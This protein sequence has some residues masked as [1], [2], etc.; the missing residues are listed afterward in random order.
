MKRLLR[1][2]KKNNRLIV[3]LM[4]GTSVDGVDA[5]LVQIKGS[6]LKTNI[7]QI[8]Y[9]T[10]PYPRDLEEL[11]LINSDSESARLREI[12][13]LN[14]LLGEFFADAA[15]KIIKKAR[16]KK[17]NVDLIGTHGQTIYHL[18]EKEKMFRKMIRGTM[19]IG[20]GEV[21][22]KKTGIVTVE[23]FR[24]GDVAVGGSGA[25]LVPYFDYVM[26]SSNKKD[27]A[28]LNIGGIA[29]ITVIP[30]K[31]DITS[32]FAFDTGPGN[33][34]IDYL[35]KKYFGKDY[36]KNGKIAS[37]GKVNV[38]LLKFL[39]EHEYLK[40]KPPKS[41]GREIFG[42]ILVEKILTIFKDVEPFD[43]VTTFSEYTALS[44]YDAYLRFV[45]P[46]YEIEEVFVSGGGVHNRYIMNAL[47][48]YFGR[49]RVDE[50]TEIGYSSDAKEAICFAFL[51][52][53]TISGN[54]GNIPSATGARKRTVLGKICLP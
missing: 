38:K 8:A 27:R 14:Y 3:G 12:V 53:E 41:C 11:I 28:S 16:I 23:D 46:R 20:E 19:Q 51:A 36:D 18:P 4:S 2:F 32:V 22:A 5:V 24:A 45:K 15:L 37:T 43:M 34:T 1:I 50:F 49:V 33:M 25:P 7:T 48:K 47:K 52:N 6:G 54:C 35:T 40:K 44:I 21:I 31:S 39:M 13:Q 30:K 9:E 26:L 42:K 29:N 10:F 17:E